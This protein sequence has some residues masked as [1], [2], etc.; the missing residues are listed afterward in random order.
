MFF[1]TD[2]IITNIT[3]IILLLCMVAFFTLSERKLMGS[4]QR[5]K[6][7]DVVGWWGTLQAF[8]DGAKAV[9]K[10]MVF[11]LKSNV[12]LFLCGPF[13]V[14]ILSLVGWVVIPISDFSW[15]TS[16]HLAMFLTL[17]FGSLNVYGIIMA[18]WS[19]NSRYAFLG[20]IRA[21]A[22]M[23]SYELLLCTV[24][25]IIAFFAGSYNYVDIVYAQKNVWFV[26]PLFPVFLIYII[27]MLAETNR[28]PFDLAEAEAELVA[29]Y[30][31]EYSSIIFAMFFLGEY[32]NMILL[33]VI[34]VLYFFGGFLVW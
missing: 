10:E 2:E 1:L 18:G 32:A 16:L 3:W 6:G 7:P 31:V 4:V 24:N 15:I 17:I 25:L 28:T 29:G 19:S 30:N 23:I 21:T 34:C 20:G 5:R 22:Q 9:F 12:F 11:P 33:S 8:A 14:F 27:C 13:F 26:F